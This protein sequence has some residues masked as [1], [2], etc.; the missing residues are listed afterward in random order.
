MSSAKLAAACVLAA[1]VL[2]ACGSTGRPVAGSAAARA[3]RVGRGKVDDPRTLHY[4]CLLAHHLPV[5]L[6]GGTGLQVG[7]LGTGPSVT[8]EATPGGAQYLQIS[9]QVESA[10]VIGSALLYPNQASDSELQTIED[11]LAQGVTG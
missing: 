4:Q 11:C 3:G 1:A 2:S 8:F 9:G 5:V 10:E 7:A 6:V